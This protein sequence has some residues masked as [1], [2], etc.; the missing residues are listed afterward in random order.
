M[1]LCRLG[2]GNGRCRPPGKCL[3]SEG[4]GLYSGVQQYYAGGRCDRVAPAD[5]GKSMARHIGNPIRQRGIAVT[6]PAH[7]KHLMPNHLRIANKITRE[8]NIACTR[9]SK[10]KCCLVDRRVHLMYACQP[11]GRDGSSRLVGTVT[12]RQTIQ[13]NVVCHSNRISRRASTSCVDCV[14]AEIQQVR[15]LAGRTIM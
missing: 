2:K 3:P 13:S 15:E 6:K 11:R 9:I 4:G 8:I 1:F 7:I 14:E 12:G 10:R 5:T